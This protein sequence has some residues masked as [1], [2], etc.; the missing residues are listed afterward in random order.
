MGL[1]ALHKAKGMVMNLVIS[2]GLSADDDKVDWRV[3]V[4]LHFGHVCLNRL[5]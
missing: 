5:K 4:L 1:N 3:E 2:K